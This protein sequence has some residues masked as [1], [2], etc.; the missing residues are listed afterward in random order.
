MMNHDE[1]SSRV[2]SGWRMPEGSAQVGGVSIQVMFR[3]HL[4]ILLL[5]SAAPRASG[6]GSRMFSLARVA[7]ELS[8]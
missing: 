1:V 3:K 4:V 7:R 2:E 5:A 6:D 8:L